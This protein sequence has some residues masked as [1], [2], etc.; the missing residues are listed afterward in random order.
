MLRTK[1]YSLTLYPLINKCIDT[2][3]KWVNKNIHHHQWEYEFHPNKS[4][5]HCDCGCI[6]E[7]WPEIDTIFGKG[8]KVWCN[9]ND[10]LK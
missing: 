2:M 7:N 3:S 5:R 6:Q 9:Y 4:V 10:P 8:E 1:A